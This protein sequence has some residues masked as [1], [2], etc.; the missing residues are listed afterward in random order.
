MT[1][2]NYCNKLIKITFS[3]K[4]VKYHQFTSL[5]D[6]RSFMKTV[7][8]F[9]DVKYVDVY[10]HETTKLVALDRVSMKISKSKRQIFPMTRC[11]SVLKENS[12]GKVR[13]NSRDSAKINRSSKK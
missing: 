6:Y 12:Y 13:N 8:I 11:V 3:D 10:N 5:R 9:D 7:S 1:I 4:T 2:N